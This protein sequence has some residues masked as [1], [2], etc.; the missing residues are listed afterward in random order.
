M[1]RNE[2]IRIDLLRQLAEHLLNGKTGHKH[3]DFS[4]FNNNIENICGTS[5]CA[6][7]ELPIL[8]PDKWEFI[9]GMK[10]KLIS[11]EKETTQIEKQDVI[12]KQLSDF[13]N[14]TEEMS[15]HLFCPS[16]P[17]DDFLDEDDGWYTKHQ[18]TD[19]WGGQL[20]V[21]DATKEEVVKNII[22]FCDKADAGEILLPSE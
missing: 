12:W 10:I 22:E 3:F 4:L 6:A 1:N 19:L 20:L 13:F 5:G 16:E 15:L 7:G 17:C 9:H 14:I 21:D 2:P 11:Y 18:N 8:F